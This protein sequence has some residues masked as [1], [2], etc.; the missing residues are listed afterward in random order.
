[1]AYSEQYTPAHP[2]RD[3]GTMYLF[4]LFAAQYFWFDRYQTATQI[5]EGS[6]ISGELRIVMCARCIHTNLRNGLA[7][8]RESRYVAAT[9]RLLGHS[10]KATMG[11]PTRARRD[12]LG[13]RQSRGPFCFGQFV[14]SR[15]V[16]FTPRQR[17]L[18]AILCCTSLRGKSKCGQMT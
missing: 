13:P 5:R 9:R 6:S 12:Q 14:R 10:R 16:H 1:M 2:A 18:A 8:V 15:Y 3:T 17:N 4:C 7:R 11:M